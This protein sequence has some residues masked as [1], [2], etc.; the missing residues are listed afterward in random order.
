MRASLISAAFGAVLFSTTAFASECVAPDTPV[1]PDTFASAEER[2][3]TY[4][5]VKAFI[6]V[7]SPAYLECLDKKIQAINPDADNATEQEAE[8]TALNNANV[9]AQMATK[10]RWD[11]ANSAW[12]E[13]HPDD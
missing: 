12:K 6:A 11:A 3:A 9:D 1:V 10:N 8:L 4:E 7:E 2:L 5:K 13:I